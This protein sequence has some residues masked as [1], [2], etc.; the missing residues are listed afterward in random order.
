[1]KEIQIDGKTYPIKCTAFTRFEY[2]KIFGVGIFEDIAKINKFNNQTTAEKEKLK[3]KGKTDEE[4]DKIV[5]AKMMEK[6]DEFIDVLQRIAYIEI[7][8][9]NPEVGTFEK[10]LSSIEKI[11]LADSWIGEVTEY[12]VTSFCG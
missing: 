4:I 10:W 6:L 3:A 8:T 12:A 2:K 11:S 7:Y 5:N 9:A 1:M